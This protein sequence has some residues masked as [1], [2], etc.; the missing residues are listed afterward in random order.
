[1]PF[2]F[3]EHTGDVGVDVRASTLDRLFADAAAALVETLAEAAAVRADTTLHLTL[4]APDLDLLLV[5]WL[6]ELLFRFE[7]KGFLPADCRLGVSKGDGW[8]L[9]AE[10]VGE[11]GAATRLP[12]KVLIKAVTYHALEVRQAS[13]GWTARIVFDI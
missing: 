12:I 10:V 6:S 9:D 1:M 7:T 3:F 5:D 2:T 13:N 4:A 8:R 11:T